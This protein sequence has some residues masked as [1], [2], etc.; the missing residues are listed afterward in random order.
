VFE[1]MFGNTEEIAR[2][3][4]D[5]L[6]ST[7]ETHITDVAHAPRPLADVDLLVVGGPTHAFGLSR[8][9]TRENARRRGA[10]VEAWRSTGLREWLAALDEKSVDGVV[11]ATFDTR[12]TRP[13][14]PGSA[15]RAARRQLRHK[16]AS[17]LRP[18]TFWVTATPGPL[19]AGET[20]RARRW[21]GEL[22]AVTTRAGETEPAAS[23]TRSNPST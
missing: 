14:L 19:A 4:A 12:V 10:R 20:D 11:A 3:I 23:A 22:A 15:A 13:R 2:A 18:S 9:Q 5:G 1:S 21:G 6:G 7:V 16:G 8:P 17:V